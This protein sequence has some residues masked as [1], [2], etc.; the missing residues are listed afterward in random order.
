[1]PRKVE[2][3]VKRAL[4]GVLLAA[5]L[6]GGVARAASSDWAKSEH[7]SARLLS[8]VGGTGD[9]TTVPG[10]LEIQLAGDW[11]TY[12]RSPGDAGLPP[13]LD[14][15]GSQNLASATLLYPTPER[16]TVLGIQTFG[17][18]HGVVFPLDLK[19]ADKGKPLE[20]KLGP[21]HSWSAQ[22]S[23]FPSTSTSF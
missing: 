17:Y 5:L 18:K 19:L 11:K 23:A 10:G 12:W 8:A 3:M 21:R 4:A 16:V 22:S 6:A 2:A 15:K 9:L 20:L 13:T 1:M 14:W 7:V